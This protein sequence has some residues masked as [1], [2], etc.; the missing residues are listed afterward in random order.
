MTLMPPTEFPQC[1]AFCRP[2][3]SSTTYRKRETATIE[4]RLRSHPRTLTLHRQTQ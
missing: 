1:R 2:P 3:T 4:R